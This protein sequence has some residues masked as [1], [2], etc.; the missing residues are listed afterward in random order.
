MLV[1]WFVVLCLCSDQ[2]EFM[3]HFYGFNL[4][5]VPGSI[6]CVMVVFNFSIDLFILLP[7]DLVCSQVHILTF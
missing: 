4:P 2:T 7:V 5:S 1:F 3:A 6:F